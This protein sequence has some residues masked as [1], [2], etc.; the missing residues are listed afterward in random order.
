VVSPG[1]PQPAP[2]VTLLSAEFPP[3]RGR[4]L[5]LDLSVTQAGRP[6]D[7]DAEPGRS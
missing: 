5:Q 4:Q 2:I 7:H 3:H 1:L 6:L